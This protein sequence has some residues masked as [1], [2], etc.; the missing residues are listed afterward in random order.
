VPLSL[1]KQAV[2]LEQKQEEVRAAQRPLL[3]DFV[4]LCAD[5]VRSTH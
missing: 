4:Q 1:N 5:A 3:Q 2:L